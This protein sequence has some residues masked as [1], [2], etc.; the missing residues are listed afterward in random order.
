MQRAA[1]QGAAEGERRT[2]RSL[3]NSPGTRRGVGM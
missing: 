2:L 1:Q 3:K